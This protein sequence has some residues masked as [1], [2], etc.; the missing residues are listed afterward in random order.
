MCSGTPANAGDTGLISG[1]G[2]Y[3]GEGNGNP[4]QYSCLKISWTEEPGR[5]QSTGLQSLE[6]P[7]RPQRSPASSSIWGEDP[8][9]LSRPCTKRRPSAREDGGFLENS[10]WSPLSPFCVRRPPLFGLHV[11]AAPSIWGVCSQVCQPHL[12]FSLTQ[13]TSFP[14]ISI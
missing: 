9:L 12:A 14:S 11:E 2:K 3:P 4:F 8:G 10:I 1:S 6:P 7:E 13:A 5:L